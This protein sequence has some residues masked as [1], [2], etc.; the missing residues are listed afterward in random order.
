MKSF[1]CHFTY[2]G[3]FFSVSILW[4]GLAPQI[5][6]MRFLFISPYFFEDKWP[7]QQSPNQKSINPYCA[8]SRSRVGSWADS[9]AVRAGSR[10]RIA[11]THE[12]CLTVTFFVGQARSRSHLK[13]TNQAKQEAQTPCSL[14]LFFPLWNAGSLVSKDWVPE[15]LR[16]YRWHFV[17]NPATSFW[18]N[19]RTR[20]RQGD[21]HTWRDSLPTGFLLVMSK[22]SCQTC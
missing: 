20:G 5:V 15:N 17:F 1:M 8:F 2:L 16:T 13:Q 9:V 19:L 22:K 7:E 12:A 6:V 21:R 18:S 4:L 14:S 10:R 3:I 11:W